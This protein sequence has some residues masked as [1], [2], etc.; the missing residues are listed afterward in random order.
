MEEWKEAACK[1][2]NRIREIQNVGLAR[3]KN[4]QHPCDSG[5]YQTTH[6]PPTIPPHTNGIIPKDVDA[7]TALPFP[8]KKLT[9]KDR[10]QYCKE[11]RC[12]RCHTQGHMAH[13]CLKTIWPTS[14]HAHNQHCCDDPTLCQNHHRCHTVAI[15]RIAHCTCQDLG[16]HN[17]SKTQSNSLYYGPSCS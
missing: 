16:A 8:F 4:N 3:F 15:K 13:E 17:F 12:F 9:D 14:Q 11:G 6:H 5:S 7:T 2:V 1:E 10:T